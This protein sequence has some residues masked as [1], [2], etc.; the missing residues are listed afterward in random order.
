MSNATAAAVVI[1]F[2][3]VS[4][5]VERDGNEIEENDSILKKDKQAVLE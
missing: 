4:F 5:C 3:F 2:K 1:V